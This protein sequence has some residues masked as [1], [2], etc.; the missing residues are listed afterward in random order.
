MLLPGCLRCLPATLSLCPCYGSTRRCESESDISLTH[1]PSSSLLHIYSRPKVTSPPST[2]QSPELSAPQQAHTRLV[3][4][5]FRVP[6]P[7]PPPCSRPRLRFPASP[8][9]SST[10]RPLPPPSFPLL[11]DSPAPHLFVWTASSLHSSSFRRLPDQ[12]SRPFRVGGDAVQKVPVKHNV[13][14]AAATAA[15]RC[16]GGLRAGAAG[17]GSHQRRRPRDRGR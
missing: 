5:R 16:P 3:W 8:R 14:R 15:A 7:S 12:R 6:P 9:L 1:F 17:S 13:C 10:S 2:P 11:A 4:K